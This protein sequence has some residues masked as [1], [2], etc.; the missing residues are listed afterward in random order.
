MFS[1]HFISTFL[2]DIVATARYSNVGMHLEKCI[3]IWFDEYIYIYIRWNIYVI[4]G[5]LTG[6]QNYYSHKSNHELK[7][8]QE[9]E[10]SSSGGA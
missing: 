10:T 3:S 6:I 4:V 5:Y 2:L 7:F 8:M 9:Y 1:L